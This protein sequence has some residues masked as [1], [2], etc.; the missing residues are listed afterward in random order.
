MKLPS[1]PLVMLWDVANCREDEQTSLLTH[2][3][4][5]SPPQIRRFILSPSHPKTQYSSRD[6]VRE[7]TGALAF[8]MEGAGV[9]E[10]VP[11]LVVRGV[12]DY[13]DSHKDKPWQN[14]AATAGAA[15]ARAILEM[16]AHTDRRGTEVEGPGEQL[17]EPR[18]AMAIFNGQVNAR[19]VMAGS[20]FSGGTHTLNFS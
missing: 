11:A 5:L 1:A 16:Y 12:C 7:D 4:E 2:S 15:A 17:P 8:E 14:Y 6:R 20:S 10:V 13:A 18:N 19:N 9:W 3:L